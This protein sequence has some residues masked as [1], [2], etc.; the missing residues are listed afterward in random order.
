M[1]DIPE[2]FPIDINADGQGP[3]T[4]YPLIVDTICWGCLPPESWPCAI[5][6]KQEV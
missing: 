1:H 6:S 2:H 3:E 5:S 4:I